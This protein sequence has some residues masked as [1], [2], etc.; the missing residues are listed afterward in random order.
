MIGNGTGCDFT[1]ATG[2]Q[3]GTEGNPI[4]PLLG[5]LKDNGGLT[6]IHALP[7]G[8]PANDAIPVPACNDIDGG[9]G[10]CR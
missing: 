4:D 7:A 8:S 5:P 9:L 6:E 1:T 3:V 10:R 2:D